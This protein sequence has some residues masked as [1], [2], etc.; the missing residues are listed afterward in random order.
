R[1]RSSAPDA[2]RSVRPTLPA[3]NCNNAAPNV[4]YRTPCG[5][6]QPLVRGGLGDL[7]EQVEY[8]AAPAHK[9]TGGQGRSRA[10]DVGCL[11]RRGQVTGGGT[12]VHRGHESFVG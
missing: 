12:P 1:E 11:Q 7:V 9:I 3:I 6:A 2:H 10:G 4:V 5:A 8:L